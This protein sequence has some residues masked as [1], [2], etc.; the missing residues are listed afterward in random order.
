MTTRWRFAGLIGLMV[1]TTPALVFALADDRPEREI[2]DDLHAVVVPEPPEDPLPYAMRTYRAEVRKAE[3]RRAA[4]ILELFQTHP[5]SAELARLLP[6]RWAILAGQGTLKTAV[7][8]READAILDPAG[9]ATEALRIEA[10]Y[11]RAG[12]ALGR[13]SNRS[14]VDRAVKAIDAF[15]R[16]APQDARA[17]DLLVDVARASTDLARKVELRQR[18]ARDYPGSAADRKLNAEHRQTDAVGQPFALEFQDAVSGRAVSMND[19]KGKVVVIDFWA[20]WCG[21]CV[22]EL[23]QM[24]KLYDQY[25]DEGVEFIGVSLDEPEDRGGLRALQAFVAK[26]EIPWPQY[27]QGNGWESR[28]SSSWGIRAIPT[29]FLVDADGKLFATDARGRLHVW[30]PLLVEK[31]RSQ[32]E[33]SQRGG[34]DGP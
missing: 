26:H 15:A 12:Q 16:L 32:R 21:P 1:A 22:A 23:P 5:D 18:V 9:K 24:K 6:Q 31:A 28:F 8:V 20:T 29:V 10:A 11:F 33:S 27:Y 14:D 30:L 7:A 19:L 4:L 13:L 2:L 17:A 34:T 25:H 3:D